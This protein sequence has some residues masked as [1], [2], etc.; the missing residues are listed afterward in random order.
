MA[1]SKK[2]LAA[3]EKQLTD[4]KADL[5]EGQVDNVHQMH[6]QETTAFPDPADQAAAETDLSFDIRIKSR[7]LKLIHKIDETLHRLREGNFGT[8]ESCS[9]DISVKRLQARPVTKLCIDCKNEQ[10]QEE[11]TLVD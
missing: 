10:E 7:E 5:Q 11:K 1:L 3:F 9:G 2:E 6:D 8:C 4:W